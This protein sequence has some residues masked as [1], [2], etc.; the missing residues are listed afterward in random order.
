MDRRRLFCRKQTHRRALACRRRRVVVQVAPKGAGEAG[1]L[2]LSAQKSPSPETDAIAGLVMAFAASSASAP[3][4]AV[5]G[6][7]AVDTSP[8][9]A[10]LPFGMPKASRRPS[11]ET[12]PKGAANVETRVEGTPFEVV[13]LGT[14]T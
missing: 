8:E 12:L 4:M 10:V 11:S 5:M 1:P 6:A 13:L 14:K 3:E 2:P 9:E 7:T